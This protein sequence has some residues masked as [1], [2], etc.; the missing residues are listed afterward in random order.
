[1]RRWGWSLCLLA[2]MAA[3][4]SAPVTAPTS[5]PEVPSPGQAASLAVVG[6]TVLP[7]TTGVEVLVDQTVLVD[8]DRIVAVG[9]SA[10]TPV[11]RGAVKVDGRGRWLMPGLVDMHLHLQQGTGAI[12]EPAGQQMRL[13]LANG[14]TTARALGAAPTGLELRARVAKGRGAGA[15]AAGGRPVLPCEV[16]EGTGARP[17]ARARAEGRGL[18][19]AQDAWRAGARDV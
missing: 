2:C 15:P 8:G 18:R 6:V 17:R 11:P 4:R 19:P 3:C 12:S 5:I 14:V 1:M 10:S 9:P 16:R 13:L 7:M